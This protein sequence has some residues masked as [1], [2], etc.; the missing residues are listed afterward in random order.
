MAAALSKFNLRLF[1]TF[2]A[3]AL[4][5]RLFDD[6]FVLHRW[7]IHSGDLF[8]YRRGG[9]T[10]LPLYP[11]WLLAIEWVIIFSAS[12]ALIVNRIR[13][14][15]LL[16]TL[17]MAMSL[18][19]MFQNQKLLILIVL[20]A[21]LFEQLTLQNEKDAPVKS[22]LKWQIV[23]VYFF[24]A[25]HKILDSFSRG[26]VLQAI[27]EK[28]LHLPITFNLET[29]AAFSW[30]IIIAELLAPLLL[31]L[32]PGWGIIFVIV[33]HS[34]MSFFMPNILAFSFVMV[35]LSFLFLD[36]TQTKA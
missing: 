18:T 14:G 28:V 11:Q 1:Y 2:L 34:G 12:L 23:L 6:M 27:A 32:K 7:G 31:L 8:P 22:F 21:L 10:S 16:A 5:A 26:E 29:Y 30:A 33:L 35:A 20:A 24:S 19:Q 9:V 36:N 25:F 3:L 15:I 13:L 4:L 17:G